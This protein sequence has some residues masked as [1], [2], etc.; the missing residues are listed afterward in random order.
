MDKNSKK[1][2]EILKINK[3]Y[4]R[5]LPD[6]K[7]KKT[8]NFI[9]LSLTLMSLCIF[10]FFAI[11]PT[12]S[13]IVQLRKQIKDNEDYYEKLVGKIDNLNTLQTKYNLLQ[14]DLS[15]VLIAI[16][17]T[18][19]VP[20]VTGQ[21]QTLAKENNIKLGRIQTS[22]VDLFPGKNDS[23]L[24]SF[25]FSLDSQGSYEDLLNFISSL[26]D[27][28]RTTTIETVSISPGND[29]KKAES[30]IMSIKGNVY[31]MD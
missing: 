30:L 5:M 31:F 1:N 28:E 20:R 7:N 26:V 6:L 13:T 27:F 9:G 23:K 22:E 15:L 17:K 3:K 12:I 14:Q 8:Q 10:G 29:L 24:Y 19:T 25:S 11:S 16:P 4:L 21:L 18:P 2:K